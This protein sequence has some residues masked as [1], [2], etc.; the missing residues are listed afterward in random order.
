MCAAVDQ[1]VTVELAWL[2]AG[3]VVWMLLYRPNSG[4]ARVGVFVCAVGTIVA[5]PVVLWSV[6]VAFA[7]RRAVR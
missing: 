5:W 4:M 3:S 7:R 2:L 1:I 6:V